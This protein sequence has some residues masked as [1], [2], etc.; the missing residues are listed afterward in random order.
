MSGPTCREVRLAL[1]IY[2]VGAIDPAERAIVEEHLSHCPECREELAGLAG[3]PALLGRV[4]VSDA[5]RLGLDSAELKDLEEP[6]ARVLSSL[7]DEVALRRKTRRWRVITAAAA[8]AVIAV[9]G[10]LAGGVAVSNAL[11]QHGTSSGQVPGPDIASGASAKT[12]V[13]ADVSYSPA[14]SGTTMTVW[15]SGVRAGTVCKLWILDSD[16]ERSAAGHWI[17]TGYRS[18]GYRAWSSVAVSSVHGFQ[19]TGNGKLLVYIPA[20]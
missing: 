7:L 5:E 19:I 4:P 18:T 9:G 17:A 16:G 10:G 8:A 20:S 2:V 1:G 14:P 11:G 6:P 13:T 3:L 15:V 12:H